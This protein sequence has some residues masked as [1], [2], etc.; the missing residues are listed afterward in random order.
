MEAPQNVLTISVMHYINSIIYHFIQTAKIDFTD[1]EWEKKTYSPFNAYQRSKLANIL[2]TK[3][4]D[5]RLKEAKINDVS[6]YVLHPGVI[7]TEITRNL[8][9][10]YFNG[11]TCMFHSI[12]RFFIKTPLQGSQTT[13]YC[14][15]D[16]KIGKQS[17]LYYSDCKPA[18]PFRGAENMDT[19]KK[20]WE[21]SWE[22]VKLTDYNPFILLS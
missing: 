1:L 13:I 14:A 3:E 22:L 10:L 9:T 15:I 5:R 11:I 2:F 17:G 6:I 21:V 12:A 8:D 18:K 16:E 20:L 4:L 19:A 7:A